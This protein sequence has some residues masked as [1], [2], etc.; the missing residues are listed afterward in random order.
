MC[1]NATP[2]EKETAF[3]LAALMEIPIQY[4][5]AIELDLLG[6]TPIHFFFFLSFAFNIQSCPKPNDSMDLNSFNF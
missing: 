3:A 5:A 1:K 2:S 6:Y 4:K